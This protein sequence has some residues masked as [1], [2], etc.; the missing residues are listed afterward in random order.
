MAEISRYAEQFAK[1]LRPGPED[2]LS[3][4]VAMLNVFDVKTIF[5]LVMTLLVDAK[6]SSEEFKGVLTDLESYLV[7]R[8]VCGLTTKNY[9]TVFIGWLAKLAQVPSITRSTLRAAMRELTGD[10]SFWPD[11]TRFLTAWLTSPIYERLKPVGRIAYILDELE[12]TARRARHEDVTI[13]TSLTVEHVLPQAWY[14]YWPLQDGSRGRT[15]EERLVTPS[16]ASERRDRILHTMGNLTL[17]T[18][19]LNSGLRHYG[20]DTK[21]EQIEGYSI[22]VLNKYFKGF[23]E[24]HAKKPWD[25]EAI[26]VRGRELFKDAVKLWP[27]P[28]A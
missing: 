7:R 10:A 17:L 23:G 11:D 27:F 3:R 1:L 9:N 24:N 22:L 6:L 28:A 25:E 13:H 21:V 4:F 12:L 14:E 2:E 26:D 19:N 18:G 15:V 5:P 8:A 20:L 16:P